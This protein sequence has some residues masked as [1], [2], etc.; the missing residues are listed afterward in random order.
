MQ[1][2]CRY[3]PVAASAYLIHTAQKEQQVSIVDLQ[4]GT[5]SPS[6]CPLLQACVFGQLCRGD[7]V[8]VIGQQESVVVGG[9][10]G[11]EVRRHLLQSLRV[12]PCSAHTH[13]SRAACLPLPSDWWD[14]CHNVPQELIIGFASSPTRHH[15]LTV[16]ETSI[17]R[18][19]SQPSHTGH[20][21]PVVMIV[22]GK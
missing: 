8:C 4:L 1:I 18:S 14:R 6:W 10:E 11:R 21:S 9:G 3:L 7:Y 22:V 15:A 13:T 17:R 19:P 16:C 2:N 5:Q 12:P 20:S